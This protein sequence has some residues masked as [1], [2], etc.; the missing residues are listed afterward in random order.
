MNRRRYAALALALAALSLTTLE[1]RG[2]AISVTNGLESRMLGTSE[3]TPPLATTTS[4]ADSAEA[5][6]RVAR[7]GLRLRPRPRAELQAAL[8]RIDALFESFHPSSTSRSSAPSPRPSTSPSSLR[9]SVVRSIAC[10]VKQR[11][12]VILTLKC[13][14][15]DHENSRSEDSD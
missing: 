1:C 15:L 5:T 4:F 3:A 10:R 6:P 7:S 9:P 14:R 8:S 11:L 13:A 2:T 12:K